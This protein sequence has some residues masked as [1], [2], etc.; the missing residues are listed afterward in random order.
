M[1]TTFG[2]EWQ[3]SGSILAISDPVP[4]KVANLSKLE[5]SE[6]KYT[7]RSEHFA[8]HGLSLPDFGGIAAAGETLSFASSLAKSGFSGNSATSSLS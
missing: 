3:C 7:S 1:T 4:P 6:I 5:N 2:K 8:V